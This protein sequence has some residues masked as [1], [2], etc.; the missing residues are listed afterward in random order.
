MKDQD[1]SEE[2]IRINKV[3]DE[4]WSSS[5]CGA[6][7]MVGSGFSKNALVRLA[8]GTPIPD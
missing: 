4:L 8:L 2:Q 5:G 7:V 1:F 6:S 3:R